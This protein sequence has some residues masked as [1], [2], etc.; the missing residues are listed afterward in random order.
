M[1][2]LVIGAG[3]LGG[4]FGACMARAGRDVT[5]L[6]RE[7]RARQLAKN[8]LRVLSPH[9]DFSVPAVTVRA[10][11]IR[12]TF[13]LILVGAK[14]Y[15]LPEA[16]EQFAPAVGKT[17]AI[18]PVLNGMAHLDSLATRF[19]AEHVLGGKALISAALDGEGRIV[20]FAPFH[21]LSFG[22]LQGGLSDRTHALAALFD[23]CG[24]DAPAKP[25]ILQD[26]WDKFA[27]LA[28]GAGMTCLMR[29]SSGDIQN[30][31]GGREAFLTLYAECR[32]V[33]AAAG[34][35]STPS[36]VEFMIKTMIAPGSPL[37]AS[38]LRD[39]ERG[40]PTEG[41]HVFGDLLA[42]AQALGVVTPILNLARIHVAT[43]EIVRA[44]EA[45][46]K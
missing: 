31:P 13:D 18:L 1:R 44:K 45:A 30:A 25:N 17:T 14:A 37:K 22:E 9:G 19:G 2:T 27:Q 38:M 29:G 41:D 20:L 34:F 24:F 23:G 46:A 16:M 6:V 36:Y 4:Y 39:I 32:S 40:G 11:E 43:Y 21:E 5:F 12:D 10:G 33:A 8:G 26:M 7:N 15:S 35:A 28:A 3:A 42:R